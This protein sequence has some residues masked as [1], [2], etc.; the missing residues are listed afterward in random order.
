MVGSTLNREQRVVVLTLWL[1]CCLRYLYPDRTFRI[2]WMTRSALSYLPFLA[3]S[4]F[5]EELRCVAEKQVLKLNITI[6]NF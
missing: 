3:Q 1:A 4:T 2:F 5:Q 6:A